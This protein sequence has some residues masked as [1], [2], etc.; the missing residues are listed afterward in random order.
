MPNPA[1]H[2]QAPLHSPKKVA[3]DDSRADAVKILIVEDNDDDAGL[4]LRELRRAGFEPDWVRVDTEPDYL[5][6]LQ[7]ELDLVLSDFRMPRFSGLRALELMNQRGL[8]IPFILVSGTI[9]E[10][11]AVLAM[12]QGATDYLLKDR[13]A[14]LG[15]A[16][17]QA[18]E[19]TRL[20]RERQQFDAALRDSELKFRNVVQALPAAVYTC[21]AHGR[22][23]LFNQAAVDLWGREPELGQDLWC[24]S[25][26]I[27]D[28]DGARVSLDA[29]PMAIAIKDSVSVRH[30]EII[31][32]RPDGTRRNVVPYP[33]AIFDSAGK[34]VGAVNML[35][36]VT[37]RNR[38]EI[39][40]ER[41]FTLSPDLLCIVGA[42]GYL[43]RLNPAFEKTLGYTEAESHA[44]PFFEFVHSDD[45]AKT[46]AGAAP[47]QAG[48]TSQNF[49]NRYRCKDGSYRWIEWVA[50][51]YLAEGT[52]Y[53]VGR[54]MTERKLAEVALLE[55]QQRLEL[56]LKS[57]S[58]GIWELNLVNDTSI[59]TLRH[60]QIFGYETPLLEWGAAILLRHVFPE[61][62]AEVEQGFQRALAT[63]HLALHCRIVWPDK[64]LHWLNA[65]GRVFYDE[66]GAPVRI[67]GVSAD[68]TERK[69]AEQDI[70]SQLRELQRWHEVTLGREARVLALKTEVNQL[71]AEQNK[72]PRYAGPV[73]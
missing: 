67:L 69:Q 62:R 4:L 28:L 65:E 7:P 35:I 54:D 21:D 23:T 17:T 13:L 58:L 31:I 49:E 70:R 30:R 59:R 57:A 53:A 41:F 34:I 9:G 33:E 6:H 40:R 46:L 61:D 38:A 71:L 66:K 20:R 37:D 55:S 73:A 44:L 19:Q 16:V 43:Q 32:E 1:S 42:D 5:A 25:W 26:K 63:G 12:K 8:E 50:A 15:Q 52:L 11:T 24:G 2:P 39:E 64:S 45:R 72:P 56:A 14:R 27:Y 60:D 10:E 3:T 47:V 22:I 48:R 36:D 18:L 68:V 51:P 29:C